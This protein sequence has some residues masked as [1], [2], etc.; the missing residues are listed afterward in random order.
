MI[1]MPMIPEAIIAMLACARIGAVHGVVFGGFAAKELASRI[2]DSRPKVIVSANGGVLP[3]GKVVEY[4]PLLDKALE[5][6][7]FGGEVKRCVIVNRRGVEACGMKKGRDVDYEELM[8]A[9]NGLMDAVPLPSTHP[10]YILY[11][12]GKTLIL[13]WKKCMTSYWLVIHIIDDVFAI[14][15]LRLLQVLLECP[16][17]VNHLIEK[18]T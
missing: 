4:K 2:D 1:Y 12:S 11:T 14:Y 15:V 3:G 17:W 7:E 6:A 9:G 10:H 16:R 5:M 8:A 18:L 13:M